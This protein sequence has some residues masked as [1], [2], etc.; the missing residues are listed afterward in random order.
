MTP[1]SVHESLFEEWLNA[2]RGII[3][4]VTRAFARTATEAD[5]LRQ[6][7]YLQLWKSVA[8]FSGQARA[9]TW[10]YKVCL[11]TGS[12]WRRGR[13]RHD[14]KLEPAVDLAAISSSS[15]SPD[16]TA[17]DRDILEKL[18]AAIHAL[19]DLDRALVLLMLD[20]QSYREI[21][22]VIGITETHVGVALTRARK[23]LATHLKGVTDELE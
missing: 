2:H 21:A 7:I 12:A 17:G 19:D 10:I 20:G 23:R 16:A 4:K 3:F 18:Y 13:R 1:N 22:E 6:E 15:P 5:E 9:S 8:G 14:D 11:N